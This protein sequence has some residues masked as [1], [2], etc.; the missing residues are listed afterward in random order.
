MGVLQWNCCIYSE[1]LFSKTPLDGC[2]CRIN[3]CRWLIGNSRTLEIHTIFRI[4]T[5]HP[6]HRRL[7]INRAITADSQSV[8]KVDSR[9]WTGNI[10][11]P[12]AIH[13]PLGYVPCCMCFLFIISTIVILQFQNVFWN[14]NVMF[15]IHW[16]QYPHIHHLICRHHYC[17][18]KDYFVS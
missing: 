4:P 8:H 5:N 13:K 17:L 9:T 10:W 6:L 3:C 12:S 14:C 11:F 16:Q 7:S 1:Y 15:D 2:F 18:Q